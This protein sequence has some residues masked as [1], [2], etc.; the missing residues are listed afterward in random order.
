VPQI[1]PATFVKLAQPL[2]EANDVKGLHTLL[3]TNWTKE[4][5]VSLLSCEDTDARKVA[6]LALSLVGCKACIPE[7]AKQ[8]LDSDPVVN[9]MAE[10]ALWNIW[11]RCGC[12]EANDQIARGSQAM[13]CRNFERAVEHFDQ[14]IAMDPNFA[15]AYHQ[16]GIA[17][18]LQER[19]E[20]S[21]KD[22]KR[23]T[24]LMPCHFGAWAGLGHCYAHMHMLSEAK[25]AY[26]KALAL[27]PHLECISEAI[28]EIQR[29]L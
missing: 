28:E 3:K 27:N 9:Q 1:E 18:Y 24:E 22:C 19:Y 20:E 2:L 25:Q 17:L 5:I 10:H 13:N 29:S 15:E 11:F 8:L 23:T 7:I 12:N 6:A 16:R 26:E 21:M 4:Q 14:A